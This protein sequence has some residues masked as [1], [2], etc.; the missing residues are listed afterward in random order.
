MFLEPS[1]CYV[2]AKA[3]GRRGSKLPWVLL[4]GGGFWFGLL[5]SL[6]SEAME[7]ALGTGVGAGVGAGILGKELAGSTCL[8]ACLLATWPETRSSA[9]L[10]PSRQMSMHRVLLGDVLGFQCADHRGSHARQVRS[11]W[12]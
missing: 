10:W 3:Q 2:H 4:V 9:A 8:A 12:T 7:G 11:F 1:L 5:G 6:C